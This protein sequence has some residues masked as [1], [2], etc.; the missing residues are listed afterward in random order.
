[1]V[2]SYITLAVCLWASVASAAT[3]DVDG[4]GRDDQVEVQE[5]EL[6]VTRAS[7]GR[8]ARLALGVSGWQVERATVDFRVVERGRRRVLIVQLE[9]VPTRRAALVEWAGGKL[10]LAWS[11]A[12]GPQGP[13]GEWSVEVEFQDEWVVR[14]ESK[15]GVVRCD[16]RPVR[17]NRRRFDFGDGKWKP[18]STDPPPPPAGASTL[19][20]VRGAAG[21]PEGFDTAT[22]PTVMTFRVASTDAD[23]GGTAEG[24]DPPVELDDGDLA[25]AWAESRAQSSG[26][27]EFFTA[28]GRA[29]TYEIVALRIV[30]GDAASA[31]AFHEANRLKRLHLYTDGAQAFVIEFPDDPGARPET[32]AEPWWVVFPKP[33][34]SR[35]LTVVIDAVYPSSTNRT[36]IAEMVVLT[37]L[38]G[39]GGPTRLAEIVAAGGRDAEPAAKALAARGRAG[40]LALETAIARQ[41]RTP[42]E[43][44]NLRLALAQLGDPEGADQLAAGLADAPDDEAGRRDAA[45]YEEALA[46][47]GLAALPALWGLLGDER[48]PDHARAAAARLIGALPDATA[49]R[50]LVEALGQGSRE[51]RAAVTRALGGRPAAELEAAL[52][53]AL[54][55]A[56]APDADGSPEAIAREADRW[57]VVALLASR[58]TAPA[59]SPAARAE[60]AAA[61]AARLGGARSYELRYR[62]VQAAVAF[63]DEAPAREAVARVLAGDPEPALRLVA[64]EGLREAQGADV[65]PLL[66]RALEDVDAGVRA[67]ALEAL[68]PR[69]GDPALDE[70]IAR[71]LAEDGWPLVRRQAAA[72]L[73]SRCG[74][75][76]AAEALYAAALRDATDDVRDAALG[77]LVEC[78]DPRIGAKLLAVAHDR[79]LPRER[80]TAALRLV[81]KLGDRALVPKL[82]E[83]FAD[84]RKE[85][86]GSEDGVYVAVQAAKT[87]GALGDPAATEP[88]I[89]ALEDATHPNIQAAA[90][91]GLGSLCGPRTVAA[92]RR[93]LGSEHRQVTYAARQSLSRCGR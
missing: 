51:L 47:M 86:F 76:A 62:L 34:A 75:A 56:G 19:R 2:R 31:K 42:A 36:A 63:H 57:K 28:K 81:I 11:G 66:M 7:G 58:G 17:L 88:L 71:R 22:R 70:A 45:K 89:Q 41:G 1:M 50:A 26:V 12:V 46:A 14:Y 67:T 5:G 27:G 91:W 29:A 37:D 39:P 8:P 72:A 53:D 38:D 43:K 64:V 65:L 60:A 79:R 16:D 49:R 30:P 24:L 74:R 84:A 59:A 44:R 23:D 20:A 6:V 55:A 90:A 10:D 61:V 21:A 68:A 80:R 33:L 35:C 69:G 77:A 78:R 32:F 73:G 15:P 52:A 40:A 48:A 82:I 93:A 54:E 4:D 85:A 25:T 13:D 18:L 83:L 3:F 87:L 9:G 92:L